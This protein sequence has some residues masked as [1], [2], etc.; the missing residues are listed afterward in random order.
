MKIIKNFESTLNNNSKYKN[1]S[2]KRRNIKFLYTD[3]F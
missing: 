3:K 2:N 1:K